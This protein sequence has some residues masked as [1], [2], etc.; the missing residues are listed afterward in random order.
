MGC[1]AEKFPREFARRG[2]G[3]E[4]AVQSHVRIKAF[5]PSSLSSLLPASFG[6]ENTRKPRDMNATL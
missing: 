3:T 4:E 1:E 2:F 5:L 6:K